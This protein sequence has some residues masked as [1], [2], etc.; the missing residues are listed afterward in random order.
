MPPPANPFVVQLELH[1]ADVINEVRRLTERQSSR[2]IRFL[3]CIPQSLSLLSGTVSAE[4]LFAHVLVPDPDVG[5]YQTLDGKHVAIAGSYV[6]TKDGFVEAR[7]IRILMTDEF[8]HA[9]LSSS[10]LQCM[11]VHT[12][13]PLVGGVVVPE[14]LGEMDTATFRRY[15]AIMR[16][17]PQSESVFGSLDVFV[18]E[19]Y[20]S[21]TPHRYL[22]PHGLRRV[23]TRSVDLL[24]DNGTLD[25]EAP[26][27]MR[28]QRRL[29]LEQTIESYVMEQ[30][31]AL[32]FTSIVKKYHAEDSKLYLIWARL[33][34]ATPHDFGIEPAFQ[35]DQR[36]TIE[37]LAHT[38]QQHT[39]LGMLM[40]LKRAVTCLS[41]AINR[42]LVRH[43]ARLASHHLSTDDVLDQ[44]LYILV[45]V[46][47][48]VS[49]PLVAI[50][51]YIEEYHFVN[52]AVSALGFTLANFQVALE[53][54][55]THTLE[56]SLT[57]IELPPRPTSPPTSPRRH[58]NDDGGARGFALHVLGPQFQATVVPVPANVAHLACG[59]R[60]FFV[61][62]EAGDLSSWGDSYGG[63]L[64]LRGV[65]N[66]VDAPQR[67][68]LTQHVTQV[69]CG[70]FHALACD[71]HGH[72][73]AWG[74]NAS[75]QLGIAMDVPVATDP[76]PVTQLRGM[77]IST[78]ACGE[79]HSIA[80]TASGQVYTWGSN[81]FD[82]L[83]RQQDVGESSA[84]P[85]LVVQ[86]WGG[87]TLANERRPDKS[88]LGMDPSEPGMALRIAAGTHHSLV[89]SRDGALFAWGCG[90]HGQ[91]GHG[92]T[93][94]VSVPTQVMTLATFVAV[95]IGAGATYSCVLL[96][97]GHVLS[98]GV[99]APDGP[100]AAA[101]TVFQLVI[102]HDAPVVAVSCGRQHAAFVDARGYVL[103][104]GS[105]GQG[106]CDDLQP[107]SLAAAGL[108]SRRQRSITSERMNT[109]E[110][111][112]SS[113][114]QSSRRRQD[115]GEEVTDGNDDDDSVTTTWIYPP[116]RIVA[117]CTRVTHVACGD[118]HTMLRI[119]TMP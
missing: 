101:S 43:R 41:E 40:Q 98:S 51:K 63:R 102:N 87:R 112:D 108:S 33:A 119:E 80:L 111:D 29:Q 8:T 23:W 61:V 13:R 31:H 69:A 67:L 5:H 36:M 88:L 55:F 77:Y 110:N 27:A 94:D 89:I 115:L 85:T 106:Q 54:F 81:R 16:A 109:I 49:L 39:P 105:N 76:T 65:G 62:G 66:R 18:A 117:H 73:Y 11:L 35:C 30:V 60:S 104:W 97:T 20:A 22:K 38:A 50:L 116:R 44:L 24:L 93:M 21:P 72:V 48:R 10:L 114:T 79:A 83:G 6:V 15:V 37:I 82:Q 47:R 95:D 86:D 45:Q 17:Y 14:D 1:V 99:V 64:G 68:S 56:P 78:V 74:T 7:T 58:D 118:T 4:D 91:L 100:A 12:N 9:A 59:H 75:G 46:A 53:W 57:P 28:Q 92:S 42:H 34:H 70:M 32:V 25:M 113:S 90:H 26:E 96:K 19:V 103:M 107:S 84:V 2:P 52:S 3:V 71:R